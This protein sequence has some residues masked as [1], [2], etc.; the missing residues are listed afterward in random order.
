MNIRKYDGITIIL[1]TGIVLGIILWL[2]NQR[3]PETLPS[4]VIET[5][6]DSVVK[7]KES[8]TAVAKEKSTSLVVKAKKIQQSLP[9][10]VEPVKDTTFEAMCQ[11][12][13]NY[14]HKSGQLWKKR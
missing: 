11:Y 4:K 12:L 1:L 6:I 9:K 2:L 13:K 5:K 14:K 7:Q 3:E 8:V 10:T